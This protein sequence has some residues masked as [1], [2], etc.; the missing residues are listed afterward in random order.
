MESAAAGDAPREV[1]ALREGTADVVGRG[2]GDGDPLGCSAV[3]RGG[4]RAEKTTVSDPTCSPSRNTPLPGLNRKSLWGKP[5]SRVMAF[6]P[7]RILGGGVPLVRVGGNTRGVLRRTAQLGLYEEVLLKSQEEFSKNGEPVKM[8]LQPSLR[9]Q[10]NCRRNV[11]SSSQGC[12][13]LNP[14]C[15]ADTSLAANA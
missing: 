3:G 12:G 8:G 11:G 4:G 6:A 5:L 10:N 1:G 9:L 14:T 7:Q 2:R 13:C 15:A